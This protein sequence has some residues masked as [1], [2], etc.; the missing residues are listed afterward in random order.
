VEA[1]V[2]ALGPWSFRPSF[3]FDGLGGRPSDRT[4]A[5]ACT[6]GVFRQTRNDLIVW[7]EKCNS[8][9]TVGKSNVST[10]PE[11][12]WLQQVSVLRCI[13]G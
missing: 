12:T 6:A 5:R 11:C 8:N 7:P 4:V 9:V 13:T 1:K 3:G 2:W 10:Q